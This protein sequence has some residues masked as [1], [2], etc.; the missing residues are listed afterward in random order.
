MKEHGQASEEP[1]G[2]AED[3]SGDEQIS[4]GADEEQ[5]PQAGADEQ[6]PEAGADNQQDHQAGGLA[7]KTPS[8]V[9]DSR[10]PKIAGMLG[11]Q[12][13]SKR[14]A[15]SK[16]PPSMANLSLVLPRPLVRPSQAGKK[17]RKVNL[18]A[19]SGKNLQANSNKNLQ[20]PSSKNVQAT[21]GKKIQVSSGN[22]QP[23]SSKKTNVQRLSKA[24][25]GLAN[26][27]K[28]NQS[29]EC[30]PG[31]ISKS[32]SNE[33]LGED[34]ELDLRK[35]VALRKS[36]MTNSERQLLQ[37]DHKTDWTLWEESCLAD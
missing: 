11:K 2:T 14:G 1:I 35:M 15:S 21:A 7:A 23:K 3:K 25:S 17:V 12:A 37:L 9:E 31:N 4:V 20:A 5:D 16:L 10:A 19:S 6:Q 33:T 29:I 32:E 8:P 24:S 22:L 28:E 26:Q 36:P 13:A 34:L 18:Q 27:G 30:S